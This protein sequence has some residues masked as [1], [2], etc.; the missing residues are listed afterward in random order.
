MSTMCGSSTT[1]HQFIEFIR[2]EGI[3]DETRH[4]ELLGISEQETRRHEEQAEKPL[5]EATAIVKH[6]RFGKGIRTAKG[7]TLV[8]FTFMG[9]TYPINHKHEVQERV[10]EYIIKFHPDKVTVIEYQSPIIISKNKLYP[11]DRGS[12]K[13]TNGYYMEHKSS[14]DRMMKNCERCLKLIGINRLSDVLTLNHL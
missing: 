10:L 4:K 6:H 12:N 9:K 2:N 7:K 8:S 11:R 13:L 14:W 5:P 3:I 1:N